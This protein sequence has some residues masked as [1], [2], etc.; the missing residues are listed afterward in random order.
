MIVNYL[1]IA[2]RNFT[3]DRGYTFLNILGLAIGMTSSLLILQY[4]NHEFSYD[5]FHEQSEQIYRV[6]YDFYKGGEQVFKCATAFPR[7]GPAMKEE[8]PEVNDHARLFLRYGGGIVRYDDVSIHEDNVFQADQSFFDIFSYPLIAGDRNTLLKEPNTA[9]IS[10]AAARKYFGEDDP[11]GKRIK[12]GNNEDYEIRGVIESP[13]NSHLK[14]SLLLSYPTLVQQIGEEF[15]NAW[16]WYDFYTYLLLEPGAD[17]AGLQAK[18]P[19]FIEK[20]GG[21]GASERTKFI[22]QPLEDIH[23]YSDLIQEARVNGNGRSVYFLIL[24][25]FFILVIAWVNYINLSTARAM[26]RAREVAIRKT[27]GAVKFQLIK[28]FMSESFLMNLFAALVAIGLLYLAVPLFNNLA[29]KNLTVDINDVTPWFYLAGMFISGAL[30]AGIYPAFVLSAYKPALVLKGSLK[31]SRKGLMLRKNLVVIQFIASVGLITG[32]LIV[33]QQLRFMQDQDLGINVDQTLVINGPG[34][35][36]ND[37]LYE[38]DLTTLKKELLRHSHISSVAA[39]TE[40]PGNLI[41]WT[42]GARRLDEAPEKSTIMYK[43]GIDYDYLAGYGHQIIAGRGYAPEFTADDRSVILNERAVEVLGFNNAN[44]VVGERVRIG[45][46]TLAVVGVVANYHQEGLQKNYDQIAFLLRPGA[47]NYYSMKVSMADLGQTVAYIKEH[48][49]QIFPENPF[50]YFFLDTF[51]NSQ[52]KSEQQFGK[53]FGFFASLAIFVASLG[54]FGLASFTASQRTK[55]IGIRKALGSTVPNIFLLLSRDFIKL[56]L[57]ASFIAVPLIWLVM[58]QWLNSFAF[59]V[60]LGPGIF[61][62]AILVSL[63]VALITVSY[64]SVSAAMANPAKVLKYE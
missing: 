42:N 57:I 20:H 6:R 56:V 22:L 47:R 32:T 1:K 43:V 17:I 62:V 53:V 5:K 55:E 15:N 18:F 9:V 24:I 13:E 30:L 40:I 26:Q 51:F 41:Y 37:S 48:Y 25:A 39:S 31:G 28:Q 45:G 23:L 12:F 16:G 52:Y 33:Y 63:L 58:D 49:K 29:G 19:A 27:V 2:F 50:D 59:R 60:S 44:A 21:E 64:Q 46:D 3:R 8:F 4:I 35:V 36:A 10:T 11:V 61:A 38:N 7:V 54:L 34:I 14:I